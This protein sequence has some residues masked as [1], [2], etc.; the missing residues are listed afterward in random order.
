MLIYQ[1]VIMPTQKDKLKD[2]IVAYCYGKTKGNW[3][4]SM[5]VGGYSENYAKHRGHELLDKVVVKTL[6][7]EEKKRVKFIKNM[8]IEAMKEH[9]YQDRELALGKRDLT[10]LVRIDENFAKHVGFYALDN[11]QRTE[12]AKLSEQQVQEAKEYAKWRLLKGLSD[13]QGQSKTA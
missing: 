13:V 9:F 11:A 4:K 5:L 7:E 6:V 1:T 10:T 3:Y 8:G 12:Q 2:S